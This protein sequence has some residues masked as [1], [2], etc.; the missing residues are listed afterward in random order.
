M[1]ETDEEELAIPGSA[2]TAG[3]MSF[4][5]VT[6][7]P[8]FAPRP[9]YG[10]TANNSERACRTSTS[11]GRSVTIATASSIQ[12]NAITTT[13]KCGF[14]EVCYYIQ[15]FVFISAVLTGFALV[16]AGAV[17]HSQ[18]GEM[19]VFV[20]IGGLLVCVNSALLAIQCFVR[21]NQKKRARCYT[22][23]S[24]QANSSVQG[25]TVM[26]GHQ[27]YLP[28]TSA[29]NIPPSL[30]PI[31]G[32]PPSSNLEHSNNMEPVTRPS[33]AHLSAMD[34][35]NVAS[36]GQ[37]SP[38]YSDLQIKY[39]SPTHSAISY[40]LNTSNQGHL[41]QAHHSRDRS[42]FHHSPPLGQPHHHIQTPYQAVTATNYHHGS[43]PINL[44]FD[45]F[46]FG[47]YTGYKYFKN[48][49]K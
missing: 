17:M 46:M 31:R 49:Y 20:Y 13:Q 14:H 45:V 29:N 30:P 36:Q 37:H 12:P 4:S 32:I 10:L 21:K 35:F 16:I 6:G 48:I 23:T 44:R 2:A 42:R 5:D 11:T 7:A 1:S 24:R 39:L 38:T 25:S 41:S 18:Y 26:I 43:R 40:K 27:Q 8:P 47:H 34:Y 9:H 22:N 3:I 19:V 15:L 33:P 28:I